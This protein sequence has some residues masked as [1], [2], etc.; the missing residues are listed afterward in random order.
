MWTVL[1][2]TPSMREESVHELQFPSSP[3][4]TSTGVLGQA[5]EDTLRAEDTDVQSKGAQNNHDPFTL[6]QT[7]KWNGAA[8]SSSPQEARLLDTSSQ[9]DASTADLLVVPGEPAII[10]P[11]AQYQHVFLA[12]THAAQNRAWCHRKASRCYQQQG[13]GRRGQ[14]QD[15]V[16]L[17]HTGS[18]VH[19]ARL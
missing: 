9:D 16:G 13:R 4:H 6:D 15:R 2:Q 5:A 18:I 3:E 11:Y 1:T 12:D 14:E 17:R 7:Q 10:Q 8:M 19:T